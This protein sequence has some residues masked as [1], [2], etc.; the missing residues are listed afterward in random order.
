MPIPKKTQAWLEEYNRT[1]GGSRAAAVAGIDK[2][3]SPAAVYDEMFGGKVREDISG[4]PDIIRGTM[5]QGIALDMFCEATG[6]QA[7][8]HPQDAFVYNDG[9]PWAH[10]LPD[11]W[12]ANSDSKPIEIKVP[13][14]GTFQRMYLNGVPENYQLQCQH[15]MAILECE[16]YEFVAL[17][18]VTFRVLHVTIG[19]DDRIIDA[20]MEQEREFFENGK[21]GIRPPEITAIVG[22][23]ME[24]V[25]GTL[26]KVDSEDAIK[27]AQ[28]YLETKALLDDV[29]G[30]IDEAKLRL[31]DAAGGADVF[32]VSDLIRVYWK[33]QQ[34]RKTFDTKAACAAD[35]S[36]ERFYKVGSPFRSFR[37]YPI[38][39][40]NH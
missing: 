30:L 2:W 1:I 24:P 19:R 6:Q 36:L 23:E 22:A 27:A 13:R 38:N 5:M 8:E 9:M 28:S 14:P 20:L 34:G 25:G 18:P 31:V 37:A 39:K 4:N 21:V 26:I 15:G 11:G 32:E 3:S 10:I 16:T 12:I 29:E 17:C 33:E 35:P 40:E 7:E